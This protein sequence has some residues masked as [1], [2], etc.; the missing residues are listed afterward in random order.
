MRFGENARKHRFEAVTVFDQPMLFTTSH[1]DPDTI[2][3]GMYLYAV[4]HHS[5]NC[6]IPSEICTWAA[7]NRYGALLSGTPIELQ[8][9]PNPKIANS[10]RAIDPEK[11]W[12]SNG[13]QVT[14]ADYLR[15]Y[16]LQ[17]PRKREQER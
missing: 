3:R 17:K 2:P 10:F 14:L 5:E 8:P 12:S 13:Y 9:Y 1:I 11:D 15:E 7:V 4:R 16:P 6:E